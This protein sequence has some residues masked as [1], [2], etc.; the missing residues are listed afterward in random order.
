MATAYEPTINAA[1]SEFRWKL[2]RLFTDR[3]VRP[4]GKSFACP[5]SVSI[6]GARMAADPAVTD[7]PVRISAIYKKMASSHCCYLQKNGMK[8]CRFGII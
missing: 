1:L 5:G 2:L 6:T 3:R 4:G 8:Y 7:L